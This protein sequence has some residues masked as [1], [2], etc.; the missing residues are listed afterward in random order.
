MQMSKTQKVTCHSD[1]S[2]TKKR[3]CNEH[4]NLKRKAETQSL[5][6]HDW[7]TDALDAKAKTISLPYDKSDAFKNE[8][9]ILIMLRNRTVTFS[10]QT[11]THFSSDRKL[12]FEVEEK[13]MRTHR[14]MLLP[15]NH[16]QFWRFH[17]I[18]K[19]STCS[20]F[21]IHSALSVLGPSGW[22]LSRE[23]GIHQMLPTPLWRKKKKKKK[24]RRKTLCHRWLCGTPSFFF[25]CFKNGQYVLEIQMPKPQITFVIEIF[26]SRPMVNVIFVR[27]NI[28]LSTHIFV[29]ILF[30][31]FP[32]FCH[33]VKIDRGYPGSTFF[34]T[35]SCSSSSSGWRCNVPCLRA[36][37]WCR[38]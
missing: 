17:F 37:S 34:C 25:N 24:K 27:K 4:K 19:L 2:Q 31:H 22:W 9:L 28:H 8:F 29:F 5:W 36:L 21:Q 11:S 15:R 3:K 35:S 26:L 14:A 33:V 23:T 20:E 38:N 18:C 16:G 12:S 6:S 13:A 1:I 32:A 30:N 7:S 10:S